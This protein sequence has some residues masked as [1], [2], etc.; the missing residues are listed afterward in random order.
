MNAASSVVAL[1]GLSLAALTSADELRRN[2]FVHPKFETVAPA[3]ARGT[4]APDEEPL[5]VSAILLSGAKSLVSMNGNVLGIGEEHAGYVL[6]SVAEESA[7]FMHR[8]KAITIP[9]FDGRSE[10][11]GE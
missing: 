8:G 7:V 5:R 2:P 6:T 1:L 9:L 3:P 10:I 4:A 11:N